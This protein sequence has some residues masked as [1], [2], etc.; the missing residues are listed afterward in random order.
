M[1]FKNKNVFISGATHGIGLSC[2]LDFA[3]LGANVITFSRDKKK[4]SFLKKKLNLLNTKYLVSEGDILD[5]DFL[6][7]FSTLVLKKFKYVDILIHNVGGGGSW[8]KD[9]LLESNLNVWDEVYQ[10]NNNGLII[11]NKYFLPSMVKRKWGRVIAISSIC[12]I[13]AKKEDRTWFTVSKSSQHALIKSLSKK[14]YFTKKNVTFNS[15]SPGPIFIKNTF[16]DKVR[17]E[18]PK[19]YQK[20]INDVLP[21]KYIGQP[22]DISNLCLFLCSDKANYINGSNLIID[23]GV[24]NTI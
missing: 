5:K 13:E 20:Y 14:F 19:K 3:K 10:K 6:H 15:I 17:K 4:I 8:G 12:G 9:N 7:S 21:T 22:K 2:I 16:W 23:G 11:F 1:N 18:N 24:T